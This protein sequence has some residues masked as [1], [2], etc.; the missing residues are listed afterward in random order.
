MESFDRGPRSLKHADKSSVSELIPGAARLAKIDD[1]NPGNGIKF[2]WIALEQ[3]EC[4]CFSK[5]FAVPMELAQGIV[6]GSIV[7]TPTLAVWANQKMSA[8]GYSPAIRSLIEKYLLTEDLARLSLLVARI[9]DN[10]S[11]EALAN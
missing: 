11:A 9:K 10:Q 4:E 2:S 5:V 7:V 3:P 8:L 6:P 1:Q